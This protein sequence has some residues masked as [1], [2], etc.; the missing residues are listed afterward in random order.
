ML[1]EEC[2]LSDPVKS[3]EW[4]APKPTA[5]RAF[6]VR[7]KK[8]MTDN[9]RYNGDPAKTQAYVDIMHTMSIYQ[10]GI[11][12]GDFEQ[13]GTAFA[14]DA[15]L[16][17]S[18]GM[19]V[20]GRAAICDTLSQRLQN[21]LRNVTSGT[22]FQRHNLTTRLIEVTQPDAAR[23]RSYFMVTSEIGMDHAGRY[24]DRFSLHEGGRWLISSRKIH[25]EWMHEKSR[26]HANKTMAR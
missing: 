7:G 20:S 18:N 4:P 13:V 2:R 15:T 22:V 10:F 24:E 23:A 8:D 26:F 12:D 6:R 11:D 9:V 5:L 19:Q 21:R 25:V 1:A 17:F 16:Q 14:S 3:R